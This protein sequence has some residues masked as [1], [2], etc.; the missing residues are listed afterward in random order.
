MIKDCAR[1]HSLFEKPG[2]GA[3][4]GINHTLDPLLVL[5]GERMSIPGATRRG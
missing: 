5:E 3:P 2:T 1:L 4:E